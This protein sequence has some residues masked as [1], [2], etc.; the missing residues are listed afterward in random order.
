MAMP[1]SASRMVRKRLFRD[2]NF[3]M[4]FRNPPSPLRTAVSYPFPPGG[5][6]NFRAD[7][8]AGL[9]QHVKKSLLQAVQKCPDARPPKS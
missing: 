7:P 1:V 4:K 3:F 2:R 8:A 5:V 9:Q 6:K